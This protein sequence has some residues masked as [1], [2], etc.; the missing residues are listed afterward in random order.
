MA[1]SWQAISSWAAMISALCAMVAA[2]VSV[3]MYWKARANDHSSTIRDGDNAVKQHAEKSIGELRAATAR[4]VQ[5]IEG[6]V[7]ALGQIM[8]VV[9]QDMVRM[10]KDSDHVLRPRD[11]GKVHEK[12]NVLAQQVAASDAKVSAVAEQ[13]NVIY[14]LMMGRRQ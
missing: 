2:T 11:L 10:E 14:N 8:A 7:D 3:A 1:D 9:R 5:S 6:K 13:V 12:I 4:S